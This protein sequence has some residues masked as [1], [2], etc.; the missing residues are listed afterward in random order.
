MSRRRPA[1]RPL[2]SG[3]T[4]DP[5][6]QD[7]SLQRLTLLWPNDPKHVLGYAFGDFVRTEV[8]PNPITGPVHLD[9]RGRETDLYG[10]TITEDGDRLVWKCPK[11]AK[12]GLHEHRVLRR[13]RVREVLHLMY[14]AGEP[15]STVVLDA[16]P[17]RRRF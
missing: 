2:P 6:E 15:P 9:E 1:A 12:R 8:M 7:G 13:E 5:L 3:A 14:A 17:L 11:C 4:K 16:E 10:W